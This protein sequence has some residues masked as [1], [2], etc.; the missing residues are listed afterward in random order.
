MIRAKFRLVSIHEW[1]DSTAKELEFRA[2]YD[3]ST[4]ENARFTSSTPSGEIKMA[5]ANPTALE[6]L[7]LGK[8]YYVD[9]SPAVEEPRS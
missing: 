9:F 4:P 2:I 7:Q 8:E 1:S 5:V 3:K 6:Q